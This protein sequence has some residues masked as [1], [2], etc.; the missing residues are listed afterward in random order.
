M[1]KV[2]CVCCGDNGRNTDLTVVCEKRRD[3]LVTLIEEDWCCTLGQHDRNHFDQEEGTPPAQISISHGDSQK[4]T[5]YSCTHCWL[6]NTAK[7]NF[8][9]PGL[10]EQN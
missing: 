6:T 9:M 1:V 5:G 7:N 8:P 2:E 4:C 3:L 10:F